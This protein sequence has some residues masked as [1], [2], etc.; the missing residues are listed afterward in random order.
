[1]NR[2][3]WQRKALKQIRKIKTKDTRKKIYDAVDKLSAFPDCRNVKKL[4]DMEGYRLR[5]GNWRV[6]FTADL[7]IIC[8]EEV[9][10]R[11]ENTY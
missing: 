1:M 10:R 4:T 7:K 8:I 5:V 6:I 9:R 2:I 11:N 3:K